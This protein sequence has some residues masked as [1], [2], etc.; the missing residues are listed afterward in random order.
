MKLTGSDFD[1]VVFVCQE[2]IILLSWPRIMV[3]YYKVPL[4]K[5]A[6]MIFINK[7]FEKR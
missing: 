6:E 4:N 1:F 3:C 2:I 7:S 5:F